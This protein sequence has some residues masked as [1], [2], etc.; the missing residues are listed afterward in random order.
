MPRRG[1][2]VGVVVPL[3]RALE[4]MAVVRIAIATRILPCGSRSSVV[5]HLLIRGVEALVPLT[6]LASQVVVQRLMLAKG[7]ISC[8]LVVW[9]LIPAP[10]CVLVATFGAIPKT[11]VVLTRHVLYNDLATH[12]GMANTTA[13]LCMPL[14]VELGALVE[15]HDALHRP[16]LCFIIISVGVLADRLAVVPDLVTTL[17]IVLRVEEAI[18]VLH[19]VALLRELVVGAAGVIQI[20][21]GM[22]PTE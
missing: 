17:P 11:Y 6:L 5:A 21:I 10:S 18:V 2:P 12:V 19:V 4:T 14:D 9:G 16:R 8:R 22:S 1:M 13:V 20:D 3:L 7:G 15:G